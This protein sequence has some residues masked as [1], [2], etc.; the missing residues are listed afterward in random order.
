[1]RITQGSTVDALRNDLSVDVEAKAES[2][3]FILTG[4]KTVAVNL[5]AA[6]ES[7]PYQEN[8]IL[9]LLQNTL[10]RNEQVF[11]V[12]I[13]YEPYQFEAT[14]NYWAPYYNR[15]PEGTLKF[16]QLGTPEYDYFK[17]DWYI[18]AKELNQPILSDPYF[19]FGGG[20]IWMVRWSVPFYDQT[21]TFMGVATAD[22]AFS[23]TQEIVNSVQIGDAG[24]A[25]LIDSN[26]TILGIREGRGDYEVM[27]DTMA[28]AAF[29][30]PSANWGDLIYEMTTGRTG[31]MEATDPQGTPLYVA[32]TPVGLDTGWSVALGY[33][34]EEILERTSRL[35]TILVYYTLLIAAIFGAVVYAFTRTITNPLRELTLAAG[36]IAAE[37]PDTIK[38]Q[39]VEP[40]QIQTQDE[41]ED[42][43]VAFNRMSLNLK[44][45]LENL[46]QK[47]AERTEGLERLAADLRTVS[48]VARE[49]AI[50]RDMD[51]LLNVSASLIRERLGYYHAG[52]F[53]VDERGEYAI[54]RAASSPAAETML[55]LNYRLKVG[56]TGL[57]GNVTRT[58]QAYIAL[59]TG[60]DA[61]HFENPHLPETRSEIALPLRSHGVTFGALDIQA[62]TPNAFDEEDIQTLQILADQL[63]AAIENARLTQQVESAFAELSKTSR[64]T[65]RQTWDSVTSKRN[66]P[67]YEY[68]GM[69][70]RSVPQNL[71]P[72]LLRQLEGGEPVVIKQ[73]NTDGKQTNTL[74]VP[75]MVLN[76][77]IGVIGLEQERTDQAWTEEEIA[78]A[79]AAANRAALT[80]EN[81]RLL[82]ES[83]RRANKERTIVESTTRIGSA[84]SIENILQTTAEELER[85]LGGSEITIQFGGVQE[86]RS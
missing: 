45:S 23:Q 20:G 24:Y 36:R 11:G 73:Q 76:Q 44:Q 53:L 6:A 15:T 39:L 32:Y 42:L 56:E 47:V 7:A 18:Q 86:K 67:A 35:Q 75:L 14:R 77:I 26:S 50:I 12:T 46:E 85:T 82:E 70:I 72:G 25:F 83:Q 63:A 2:I 37:N 68:D 40:I 27:V 52:I 61:V 64:E 79:R 60:R 41:L 65:I 71:S 43:A 31:F 10:R 22:I 38:D 55:G 74:L 81:A 16:T 59:D 13:A 5:A 29:S 58:G 80:L 28:H 19:D 33:P 1:I 62:N 4:T 3:Q 66:F 57:V 54:L 17:R 78:I 8:E 48:D 30:N 49:I 9:Q 34:R 69:Q 84:L 51:T 21:G